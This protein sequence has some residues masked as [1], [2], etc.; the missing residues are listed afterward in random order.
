MPAL[1]AP[2]GTKCPDGNTNRL[3]SSQTKGGLKWPRR[4]HKRPRHCPKP[5][6]RLPRG[7]PIPPDRWCRSL[8]CSSR[9]QAAMV[10]RFRTGRRELRKQRIGPKRLV[11]GR[12][13]CRH[14][15]PAPR[16][17]AAPNRKR[18]EPPE[19]KTRCPNSACRPRG[20][21]G[22][23]QRPVLR[24]RP[25]TPVTPLR[26][27]RRK[28]L[29]QS[30]RRRATPGSRPSWPWKRPRS[31]VAKTCPK[32]QPAEESRSREP[33]PQQKLVRGTYRDRRQSKSGLPL[34]KTRR[35]KAKSPPRLRV[36]V[37]LRSSCPSLLW[38]KKNPLRK[39]NRTR[40]TNRRDLLRAIGPAMAKMRRPPSRLRLPGKVKR[41]SRLR[42]A[43]RQS[44]KQAA[45]NVSPP[46]KPKAAGSTPRSVLPPASL[47]LGRLPLGQT[48]RQ[49]ATTPARGPTNLFPFP[50]GKR[51]WFRK[52]TPPAA[53]SRR[54]RPGWKLPCS[55]WN[56]NWR[57]CRKWGEPGAERLPETGPLSARLLRW[58]VRADRSCCCG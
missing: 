25:T 26:K 4:Y 27:Q 7:V 44:R 22:R 45:W 30:L 8:S 11:P 49:G 15:L 19:R 1:L 52:P 46:C 33:S 9:P 40:K 55:K 37:N 18:K 31:P 5:W 3:R 35:S 20:R 39:P 10:L 28:K 56:N 38:P 13:T 17:N 58:Q 48:S 21:A 32:F 12:T 54:F 29:R 2:R 14:G 6:P 57:C 24:P 34:W 47:P 53:S 16:R 50:L 51:R 36:T 41:N 42:M 23:R 43:M